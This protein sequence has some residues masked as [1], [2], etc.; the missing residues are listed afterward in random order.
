MIMELKKTNKT[1][2]KTIND[3]QQ[4]IIR[5][6]ILLHCPQGIEI[7]PTYSKGVFYKD[8]EDLEPLEKFDLYPHDLFKY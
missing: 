7:D 8:A 2:I 1:I 6:I 3:N 5:D 4:S